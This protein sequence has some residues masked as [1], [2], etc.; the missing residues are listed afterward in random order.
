MSFTVDIIFLSVY[1]GNLKPVFEAVFRLLKKD[2]IFAFTVERN[3][4]ET[5]S[6][7]KLL[8]SGR[9]AHSEE[10]IRQLCLEHGISA[11]NISIENIIPRFE[12]GRPVEGMLVL[13]I[14]N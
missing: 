10:Y 7:W 2:D 9:F 14:T 3:A 4:L 13:I 5:D 8:P 1:I 6:G 11:A 12:N